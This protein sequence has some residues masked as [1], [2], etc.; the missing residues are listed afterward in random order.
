M[1]KGSLYIQVTVT[2]IYIYVCVYKMYS[3]EFSRCFFFT[4][5]YRKHFLDTMYQST[6]DF[7]FFLYNICDY[8]CVLT[9]YY[10]G[11]RKIWTIRVSQTC[12]YEYKRNLEGTFSVNNLSTI[13]CIHHETV[14]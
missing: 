10:K 2:H 1:I 4:L 11:S 7:F 9:S 8:Y 14:L 3:K 13:K 5:D 12:V 6:L